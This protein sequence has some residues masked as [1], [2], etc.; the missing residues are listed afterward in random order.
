MQYYLQK[1]K[2]QKNEQRIALHSI[3]FWI[4]K[5]RRTDGRTDRI[6]CEYWGITCQDTIKHPHVFLIHGIL[7][8]CT[9][10][11]KRRRMGKKCLN[12]LQKH[13]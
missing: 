3:G 7:Q 13:T 10:D 8:S 4:G 2:L 1:K 11:T 5:E 12:I 6:Q 9:R